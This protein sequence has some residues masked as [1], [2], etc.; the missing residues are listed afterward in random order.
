MNDFQQELASKKPPFFLDLLDERAYT[1]FQSGAYDLN[2]IGIR[3]PE[4]KVDLF[5]DLLAVVYLSPEYTW[6]AETFPITTLPG[7]FMLQHPPNDH[8]GTAILKEGQWRGLWTIDKHKN[9][10][11]ALCQRGG[12][13]Q[14]IRDR[15]KDGKYDFHGP[16]QDSYHNGINLHRASAH[17]KNPEQ[18]PLESLNVARWSAGCQ[19]MPYSDHFDRVMWLARK[20]YLWG[21]GNGYSYSLLPTS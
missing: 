18:V 9:Q 13:C 7:K 12:H 11:K 2:I 5:N 14:L 19:V 3:H 4:P 16:I 6:Q 10:Y 17:W 21:L 1:L 8:L 15:N 20:Q